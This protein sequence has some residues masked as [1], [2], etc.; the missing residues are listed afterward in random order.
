MQS[1]AGSFV[2]ATKQVD[3]KYV[4]PRA[5]AHG[6]RFDLAQADVAK[7]ENAQGF[8]KRSGGIAD[9]EGE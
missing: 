4:L 9:A 6:A 2:V 3:E 1:V 5:S 7:G 8:E